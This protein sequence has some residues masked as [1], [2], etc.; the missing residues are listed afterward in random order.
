M[1]VCDDFFMEIMSH[2]HT[3]FEI[4][5]IEKLGNSKEFFKIS[6]SEFVTCI[7]NIL[8]E[9]AAETYSDRVTIFRMPEK[10]NCMPEIKVLQ[11]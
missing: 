11:A 9:F 8:F 2:S 7:T 5:K 1:R 3:K 10:R 4:T 6:K